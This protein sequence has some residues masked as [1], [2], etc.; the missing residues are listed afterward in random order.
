MNC[1]AGQ[2]ALAGKRHH[3]T[4]F[5]SA[6]STIRRGPQYTALIEMQVVNTAFAQSFINPKRC[7]LLAVDKLGHATSYK[8]E[9]HTVLRRISSQSACITLASQAGPG[10]LLHNLAIKQ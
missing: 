10:N 7:A 3:S 9:P 5:D 6:E 8:P 4:V 1:V 2:T